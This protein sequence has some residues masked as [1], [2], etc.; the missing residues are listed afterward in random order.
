MPASPRN[1]VLRVEDTPNPNALK[2]IL[3]SPVKPHGERPRGYQ[4]P[5]QAKGDPLGERLLAI[6]GVANI[7]IQSEWITVGKAPSASW[8][9]IR[10]ALDAVL[11]EAG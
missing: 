1:R 6:P 10:A 11:A 4:H 2:C 8:R 5:D 7:L 9:E 3:A